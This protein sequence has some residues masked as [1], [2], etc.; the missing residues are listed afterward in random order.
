[1]VNKSIGKTDVKETKPQK[2]TERK[3]R[4]DERDNS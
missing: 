4:K 1:M 2:G 3:E